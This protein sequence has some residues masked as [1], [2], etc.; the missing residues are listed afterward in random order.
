[1]VAILSSNLNH[2]FDM[3]AHPKHNLHVL[4]DTQLPV[5]CNNPESF[6][7]TLNSRHVDKVRRTYGTLMLVMHTSGECIM[8][9]KVDLQNM[10]ISIT[11]AGSRIE[12][13]GPC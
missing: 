6:L 10:K 4:R 3:L 11:W 2:H 7:L 8:Q 12:L 1:M 5:P 13:H 9:S